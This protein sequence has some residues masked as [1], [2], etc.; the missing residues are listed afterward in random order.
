MQPRDL[1]MLFSRNGVPK[2]SMEDIARAAGLS[3]QSIYKRF[4]SKEGVLEWVLTTY[5][6]EI[7]QAA[8][9]A[10]KDPGMENPGQAVLKVFEYWSGELVPIISMT[11]HGAE[12]LG[13][14]MRFAEN[15]DT[16][17]EGD[18]L[19]KLSDFLVASGLTGSMDLAVE[20]SN[21]LNLASKGILMRS[22]S[23]EIFSIEM[24]R[25]IQVIFKD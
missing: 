7:F 18:L 6:E 15:A 14:G 3:R 21:A 16:N 8:L 11:D 25:V 24:N 17:W 23:S 9:D 12:I 19:L 20:Q 2:T 4:G 22:R 5:I 13:I 1:L 10:L